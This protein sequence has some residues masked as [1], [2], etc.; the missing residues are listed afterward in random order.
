[1]ADP[2]DL[3]LAYL[4]DHPAEAARVLET[5]P[6][7]TSAALLGSVPARIGATVL[8]AMRAP[9][10]ARHV[11][12]QDRATAIALLSAT[13]L[14]TTA[15]VLRHVEE[16]DRAALLAG[17]P[18]ATAVACRMLLGYPENAVAAWTD[19]EIVALFPDTRAG[20]AL[21]RLREAVEVSADA[22]YVV[23]P[24][25]A[26]I[27]VIGTAALLR[28]PDHVTLA[29]LVRPV[30]A[31]LS[32]AMPLT[33]VATLRAWEQSASLPVVERGDRLIGALRR[34]VLDH[35]LA[36]RGDALRAGSG[37][38]VAGTMAEAYWTTLS[39]LIAA[40]IALLPPERPPATR[41]P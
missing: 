2:T 30:P 23:R 18:T 3:T 36:R 21:G 38:T 6:L 7:D 16:R 27:G 17:L 12:A 5:L 33:G 32:A 28:A 25:G 19:T 14:Q 34:T 20:E 29:M 9:A 13:R 8:A 10:A 15:S 39:R 4:A 22:V 26:L 40:A 41:H 37:A 31:T 1:M 11:L 35:A 24:D